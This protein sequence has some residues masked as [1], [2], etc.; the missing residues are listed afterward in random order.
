MDLSL[1][2]NEGQPGLRVSV[3]GLKAHDAGAPVAL[4]T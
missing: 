3:S 1:R 2:N 4:K